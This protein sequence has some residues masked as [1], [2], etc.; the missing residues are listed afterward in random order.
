M[1]LR[2]IASAESGHTF[3]NKLIFALL[4]VT[5]T[6]VWIYAVAG[7]WMSLETGNT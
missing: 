7:T 1:Y 3:R 4:A 6:G 2:W 5:L